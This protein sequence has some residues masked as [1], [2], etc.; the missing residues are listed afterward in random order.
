MMKLADNMPMLLKHIM[1]RI[2]IK[3]APPILAR[4]ISTPKIT[5]TSR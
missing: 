1:V 5:P 4:L 3:S 2:N